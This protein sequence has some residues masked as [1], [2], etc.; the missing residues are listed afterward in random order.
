MNVAHWH[1]LMNHL[2]IVFPLVGIFV[3]ALSWILPAENTRRIAYLIF[4]ATAI[5]SWMAMMTGDRAEDFVENIP[6]MDHRMIHKHEEIAETF[7]ALCYVLGGVSL[8]AFWF[9]VKNKSGAKWLGL[10]SL[11]LAIVT[12]YFAKSTGTSGGEIRH[13]EIRSNVPEPLFVP[14]QKEKDTD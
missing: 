6:G 9:S 14:I 4:I 1:L 8:L 12:L 5:T 13:S 3:F 11:L 7:S 10:V 2:P